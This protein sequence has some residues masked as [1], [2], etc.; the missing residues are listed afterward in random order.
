[1]QMRGLIIAVSVLAV[2]A[3]GVWWTNKNPQS[4]TKTEKLEQL[5]TLLQADLVEVTVARKGEEPLV[6]RKNGASGN[7]EMAMSPAV[8]TSAQDAMD[9][10]TNVATISAEQ[11]VEDNATD[12]IQY[13]LEPAQF[14]LSLKD[15]AGKTQQLLVGD[16][17]PVG[18]KFYARRPNEKKVFAIAQSFKVGFDKSVNDLRDK[19][20]VILDEVKLTRLE[21][22]RKADAIEFGKN[23]KGL[24]TM[25]KPQPYR[26]DAVVVDEVL[27]KV[28]EAKFDPALT[29][30]AAK[31]NAS[32]FAAGA[33]LGTL[34]FTDGAGAK[35]LEVR[36]SKDNEYLA[37]SSTVEGIYKVGEDLGK[38]FDKGL[39][40]YR[41]KKLM[42]FGFED[43]TRIQ[44]DA[45]GKSSVLE[46]KGQDWIW[47]GKKADA[48]TVTEFLQSLR[49]FSAMS[50]VDKGFAA[51]T[52]T[53][54]L[55][56]RDG[57]TLEKLMVSKVGNFHY[58]RRE[59]ETGDYE[60]DPKAF[61]ELE[62][63]AGKIKE[64]GAAKK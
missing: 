36:K 45:S 60:V 46:R 29:E 44:I 31:K 7:W 25:V 2:L 55:T 48:A 38:I 47:N 16:Q 22:V 50:F 27:N 61:A 57:K 14:T 30:D 34:K 56:Q 59:G 52:F 19:R 23:G 1:M 41:N 12:L 37:K 53:V 43:P 40:E 15:K 32:G 42:D 11:V 62:A 63:A 39:D 33:L 9:V 13:G 51:P 6:L 35:T 26:T 5:V 58:V 24:W 8:P 10:V 4:T 28:K 18:F 21:V 49:G 17:A 54:T 20:L 64:P 3:G